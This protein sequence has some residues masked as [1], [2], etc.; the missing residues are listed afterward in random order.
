ME[1]FRFLSAF[2]IYAFVSFAQTTPQD[3]TIDRGGILL[4]GKIYQASGETNFTTVIILQGFPG[5]EI[6]VLGLGNLLSL[7]GIN[8]LTFNY[9]GTYKSQGELSWDNS[10]LDI[11]AAINFVHHPENVIKY[12]IDTTHIYL[13]GYSYGGGM[14][15]S[16]TASHPEIKEVF[17]IAGNDHGEFLREY[18]GNP[19]YR[20]TIDEMF[21]DVA[22]PKGQVRFKTGTQ[23]KDFI[24]KGIESLSPIYDL[25]K[26]A[27]QL[28]SKNILLICGWN[29]NMVSIEKIILPL[30]RSLQN[31]KAQDV[32]IISFQDNH[33][34][35]NNREEVAR[36]IFDW[37]NF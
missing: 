11:Q 33:T 35:K 18:L 6:D 26:C 10:Q 15:L 13:G 29:D 9:S 37:L 31:E 3:I 2:F 22:V 19:V 5:N 8:V 23:P 27:P 36:T 30:Y 4:K 14:A 34:F 24:E 12:K 28:A 25:R 32:K 21:E 16:Y 20:K 7:R 17:S 1:Y